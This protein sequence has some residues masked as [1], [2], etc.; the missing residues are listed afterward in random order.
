MSAEKR[1]HRGFAAVAVVFTFGAAVYGQAPDRTTPALDVA[2]IRVNKNAE[3]TPS[4][5]FRPDGAFTMTRVTVT[6]LLSVAF[7]DARG[8]MV[9]LPSW[10]FSDTFDVSTSVLQGRRNATVDDR[11]NMIRGLL[12]ERFKLKWHMGT[13]EVPAYDLIFAKSDRRLGPGLKKVGHDCDAILA[14][15]RA[16]SQAAIA[17]GQ[18][19]P[20]PEPVSTTGAIPQCRM[21]E[22]GTRVEGEI[23][24]SALPLVLRG[25]A[26]RPVV[27]KTGLTGS[28]FLTLDASSAQ[29]G[30]R[31]DVSS[32]PGT[33]PSIFVA[34]EE[35]LGLKLVSSRAQL[36]ALFIDSLERPTEN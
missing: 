18:T 13:R 32:T 8:D 15:R 5:R 4:T 9:G 6:S 3:A 24:V 19:P 35:Q 21:R 25:L 10:A 29:L 11:R 36:P 12:I 2:S 33:V 30:T 14:Q 16:A 28:Y 20:P 34:V 26:A 22:A 7:G 1:C 23:P 31:G 27:D 17:A